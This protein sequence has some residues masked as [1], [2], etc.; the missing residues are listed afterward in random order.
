MRIQLDPTKCQGYGAC[1]DICPSVLE[2]DEFGFA[3][4][5]HDGVVP[6]S[7]VVAA[8]E[9]VAACPEAALRSVN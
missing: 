7:D 2:I 8:A 3:A 9:A 5:R 1:A 4:L 6:P